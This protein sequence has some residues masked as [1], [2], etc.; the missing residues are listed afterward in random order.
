MKNKKSLIILL[1]TI[2]LFSIF[3]VLNIYEY[4]NYTNIYNQKLA[5]I[6]TNVKEKYPKISEDEILKIINKKIIIPIF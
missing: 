5:N 4:H 1:I 3:M 2:I 6:I